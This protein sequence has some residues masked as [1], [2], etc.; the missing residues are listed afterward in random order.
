MRNNVLMKQKTLKKMTLSEWTQTIGKRPAVSKLVGSGLSPSTADK[1]ARGKYRAAF[2]RDESIA[3]IKKAMAE[4][5][6]AFTDVN[7]PKAS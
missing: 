1:I 7:H 6:F 4:D 5:G 2:F 3:A